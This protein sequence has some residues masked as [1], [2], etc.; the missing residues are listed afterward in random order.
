MTAQGQTRRFVSVA[1]VPLCPLGANISPTIDIMRTCRIHVIGASGAGVTSL[2][3]ALADSLALPHHDT[4]DYFWRPTT[5]PYREK[6][7]VADRLRLMR[8]VFLDRSEEHTSEL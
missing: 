1:P 8:E 3:R 4:D 5:P 6:R 2:G 7:E